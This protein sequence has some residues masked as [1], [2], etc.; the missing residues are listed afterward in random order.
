MIS[1]KLDGENVEMTKILQERMGR[2]ASSKLKKEKK[3]DEDDEKKDGE[4]HHKEKDK[5]KVSFLCLNILIRLSLDT[6]TTGAVRASEAR[7]LLRKCSGKPPNGCE[8]DCFDSCGGRGF[9][10][11]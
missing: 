5:E 6:G 10:L 8:T 2:S 1:N 7:S 3:E 11:L 9:F 4:H